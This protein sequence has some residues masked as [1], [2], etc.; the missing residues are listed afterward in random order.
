[1]IKR[2]LLFSLL[3]LLFSCGEYQKVLKSSDANYK[4]EMAVKYYENGDFNRAMPLFRELTT[5]L[6]A[7]KR[8]EEV[9]YYLAYCHYNNGNFI[10]SSYL[11]KNYI[12]TFPNGSHVEECSFMGAYCVY[13]ESPSY[14][15][16]ATY[17]MKAIDELQQFI[18][19]YPSSSKKAKCE[20]LVFELHN[21]LAFKSFENSKQYYSFI[22]VRNSEYLKT[23]YSDVKFIK[24]KFVVN[25]RVVGWS[26][27]LC[28]KLPEGGMS[29][30]ADS[31]RVILS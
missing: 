14:S 20:E 9:I 31:S 3:I 18:N 8:S 4:Y 10:T 24:L 7:T 16:D 28:T 21:K 12:K 30:A 27:S 15:L 6:R 11:F 29:P 5:M 26:I 13:L 17:T 2:T 1:M 23:L 22:A 25:N 19:M